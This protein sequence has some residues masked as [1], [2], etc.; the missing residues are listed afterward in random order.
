M[1][2]RIIVALMMSL[3]GLASVK[4]ETW[5]G[6]YR[7]EDGGIVAI[8]EMHEFG[9]DEIFVDYTTGETGALFEAGEG[10]TG[11]ARS[12]GDKV[13][14]AGADSCAQERPGPAGRPISYSDRNNSPAI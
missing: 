9:H 5:T 6:V 12:I 3:T 8:G 4:S 14:A 11:I 13:P 2:G 7:K 1:K 10:R